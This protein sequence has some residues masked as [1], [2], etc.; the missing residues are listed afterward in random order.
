MFFHA[1][2]FLGQQENHCQEINIWNLFRSLYLNDCYLKMHRKIGLPTIIVRRKKIFLLALL[3]DKIK[4]HYG[5][6]D[7]ISALSI[8]NMLSKQYTNSVPSKA[9]EPARMLLICVCFVFQIVYQSEATVL[10]YKWCRQ[11]HF[12]SLHFLL[13]AK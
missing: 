8:L 1:I 5:L 10:G 7:R 3:Q 13:P 2:F 9:I 6:V 12:V 4:Q 11:H